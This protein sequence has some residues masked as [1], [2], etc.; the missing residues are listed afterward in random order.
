MVEKNYVNLFFEII[1]LLF[2]ERPVDKAVESVENSQLS[3]VL[4]AISTTVTPL[5][6][7]RKRQEK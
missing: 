4:T 1:H 2:A 3:T 5:K 7:D 6:F